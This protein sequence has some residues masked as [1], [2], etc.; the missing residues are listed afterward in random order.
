MD[1]PANF[2]PSTTCTKYDTVIYQHIMVISKPTAVLSWRRRYSCKLNLVYEREIIM[3]TGG[4]GTEPE[5]IGF[6]FDFK[7]LGHYYSG[8]AWMAQ[9][10]VS[11][12]RPTR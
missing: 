12:K 5:E 9:R 3:S 4:D 10:L 1:C 7:Y 6:V 8:L 2:G 11:S